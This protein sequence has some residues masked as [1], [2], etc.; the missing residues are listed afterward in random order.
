M[1][2][3]TQDGGAD[4]P[5]RRTP[6]LQAVPDSPEGAVKRHVLDRVEVV[7]GGITEVHVENA[8]RELEQSRAQSFAGKDFGLERTE[9]SDTFSIVSRG[10]SDEGRDEQEAQ[11]F[12]IETLGD[13]DHESVAKVHEFMGEIFGKEE[14]D[15]LDIMQEQM[16]GQRYGCDIDTRAV[17]FA[18]KNEKGEVITTLGGGLL[19]LRNERGEASNQAVFMV[20]YVATDP[21]LR[22]YGLGREVMIS[23]YRQAMEEAKSR[24]LDFVGAAG[25]CTWRSRAFWERVGWRRAYA[26]DPDTGVAEEVPYVQ[27]PLAF[28]LETGNV[29][30][31]AGDAPEH[32]MIDLF[33]PA[34]ASGEE[35][36]ELLNG[37]VR[38]FYHTNNSVG[39]AAFEREAGSSEKA[40]AA[41][42]R[43]REAIRPHEERFSAALKGKNISFLTEKEVVARRAD[44]VTVTDYVTSDEEQEAQKSKEA[45]RAFREQQDSS[46]VL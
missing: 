27:P 45:A 44:G 36:P 9:G 41:F 28:D 23:A 2:V 26:E 30:E 34:K 19:P 7:Q 12:T 31:G 33:N 13:P 18:V 10:G 43:H 11:R 24:G 25:E 35:V 17:Y 4:I 29:E 6:E 14:L 16:R 1:G 8:I 38:A 22:Q 5:E 20:F 21:K 42:D 46:D 15:P 32:F 3:D 37:V 40:K 39:K